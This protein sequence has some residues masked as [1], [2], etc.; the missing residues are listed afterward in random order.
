[1][2]ATE[3]PYQDVTTILRGDDED[4]R[5]ALARDGATPPEVLYFLAE[6]GSA[7]VRRAVAE[8]RT[9]PTQAD[10]FLSRDPDVSVRCALARK[11]VGD[12]LDD[13]ARRNLWRMGF[14]LLET[15][16]R[17]QVVRVRRVLTEA[18]CARPDA[19][20]DIVVGLARDEERG[21]AAPMLR[22]SPVLNDE[23][24]LAILDDD[25]PDWARD[26]MAGRQTVSPALCS[27]L[28]DGASTNTLMRI[29]KNPNAV[30]DEP[31]ME[32]IVD[33]AQTEP[34]LQEP[35][36]ARPGLS[37]GVMVRLAGMIAAPLLGALSKRADLDAGTARRIDQAIETRDREPVRDATHEAPT[38][39]ASGS[40]EPAEGGELP[41]EDAIAGALDTGKTEFVISALARRAELPTDTVRRMISAQSAR[42][43]VSLAWK[44]GLGAR[45]ALDLQRQLA[46]I[47]PGKLINA[48]NGT[49]FALK[50]A[51]MNE[52]LAMFV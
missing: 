29:V 39:K 16:M 3:N 12:G 5:I 23:D 40:A 20:R 25:A 45:F 19:P 34:E 6:H 37:A 8:N 24:M 51:E 2:P 10:A 15:L 30:I 22:C 47:P 48:R 14:T 36:V 7:A 38:D 49:D 46:R 13:A 28:V 42:T 18:L 31:V 27:A 26:A 1:M 41:S 21:V 33:R 17:D 50:P 52:Q 11:A 43:V 9:T 35:L 44:A 32:R 4:A